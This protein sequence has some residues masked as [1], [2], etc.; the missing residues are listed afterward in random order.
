MGA[1]GRQRRWSGEPSG[2]EAQAWPTHMR[3]RLCV[4]EKPQIQAIERTAPVLPMRPGQPERRTHDY[5]RHGTLDLFAALNAKTGAVIGQCRPRHRAQEFRAFRP[6][7][8]A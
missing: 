3:S 8:P 2:A 4:D 5:R 1:V 6:Q 7:C